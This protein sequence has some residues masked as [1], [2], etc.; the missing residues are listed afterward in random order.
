VKPP[1]LSP[2]ILRNPVALGD[3]LDE[4]IRQNAPLRSAGRTLQCRQNALRRRCDEIDPTSITWRLLLRIDETR[5]V[6]TLRAG[7]I[8]AFN[9]GRRWQRSGGGL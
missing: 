7:L 3:V 4:W 1:E 9:Q 8:W 2:K 5:V 6:H